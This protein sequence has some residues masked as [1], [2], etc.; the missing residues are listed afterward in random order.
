[1][2]EYLIYLVAAAVAVGIVSKII[3]AVVSVAARATLYFAEIGAVVVLGVDF[4]WLEK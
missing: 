3:M 4:W 1:M 2:S